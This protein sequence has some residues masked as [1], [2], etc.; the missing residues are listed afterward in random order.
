[1][2]SLFKASVT[3]VIWLFSC[4]LEVILSWLKNI[5]SVLHI[6]DICGCEGF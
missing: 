2:F 1:M 5:Y 6:L 4:A 3:P